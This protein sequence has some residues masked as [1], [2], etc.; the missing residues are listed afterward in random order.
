MSKPYRVLTITPKGIDGIVSALLLRLA[1]SSEPTV[2]VTTLFSDPFNIDFEFDKFPNYNEIIICGLSPSTALAT[3]KYASN[4]RGQQVRYG[5]PRVMTDLR[6]K[7]TKMTLLDTS[8]NSA[9]FLRCFTQNF[10]SDSVVRTVDEK[11]NSLACSDLAYEYL[12]RNLKLSTQ[13]QLI[14]DQLVS[15]AGDFKTNRNLVGYSGLLEL[16]VEEAD[17]PI[18]SMSDIYLALEYLREN[19]DFVKAPGDEDF[20]QAL[21]K[22]TTGLYAF[23]ASELIEKVVEG[24]GKLTT[25]SKIME[26]FPSSPIVLSLYLTYTKGVVVGRNKSTSWNSDQ[27][28]VQKHSLQKDFDAHAF[29]LQY[30]GSGTPDIAYI[31]IDGTYTYSEILQQLVKECSKGGA[32]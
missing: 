16:A 19:H 1:Y 5:I 27:L 14:Y 31:P 6:A 8:P 20:M 2:H 25:R 26:I 12:R 10:R 11:G 17:D 22:T 32:V 9:H 24:M 28:V 7:N 21:S 13:E 4:K 30:G 18:T 15:M 29:A 23:E 3:S